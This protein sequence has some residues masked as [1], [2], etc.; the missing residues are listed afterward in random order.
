MMGKATGL[1]RYRSQELA[2]IH[3]GKKDLNLSEDIYRDIIREASGG[4]TESSGELNWQGR[5]AV[6]ERLAELG[7]K[8]KAKSGKPGKPSRA[9]ADDPQ[10]RMLRGMWIELHKAGQIDNPAEAA[11][12]AFVKRMT[13]K[14][15][16][17]W[18]N[19]RDVTKLK[20]AMSAMKER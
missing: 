8:A 20:K 13:G 5:R 1:D 2:K 18:L 9:L 11:L 12:C 6:L 10:S 16:L 4:K 15:A 14:D 7:W 3:I 19:N 17:Q